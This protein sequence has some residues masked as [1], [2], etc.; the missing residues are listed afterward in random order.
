M[1]TRAKF[2]TV[3]VAVAGLGTAT[4]A[5]STPS[6]RWP[7]E[8][9]AHE[10]GTFTT[11]AGENGLAIDWLP[12]G[13]P[14][15]LPCFVEHFQS[16]STI[17]VV[18]AD[19]AGPFDYEHA[20]GALL[21]KVRMETPVLY[22][23]APQEMSLNVK[24]QFPRGLMTEWYPHADVTE[25][26][27]GPNTLRQKT[28]PAVI[29]W[30]NVLLTPRA[31]ASFPSGAGES[32]YYAARATEATPLAVGSQHERFLFYRGIADFDVP[33]SA[34]VLPN[35]RVRIGKTRGDD[36]PG[37]VLFER[38]G[39]S[40]GYRVLGTL[41]GDTTVDAPTLDGSVA[42]L[43]DHL[44]RTLTD[45]GLYQQEAAAMLETWR[46]SW[47]EDGVRVF[48]IVPP[49]LVDAILPLEIRP[50]PARV[51]RVFVGRMEVL[52]AATESAVERAIASSD[53]ATL[54]RYGRFLGPI[55]DRLMARTSSAADRERLRSVTTAAL[56][57]YL[58][59]SS[60]CE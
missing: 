36:V 18:P 27:I 17:K 25:A 19:Y 48:Y 53:A 12:L 43:R 44:Q 22:F 3:L 7:T 11:V 9:T 33:I 39:S 1:F 46:D 41:R 40:L 5:S 59:K 52:T 30:K 60:V 54:D 57:A 13:G 32:H 56:T 37:I 14:T 15:D 49:K 31:T 42:T 38:R 34:A 2:A 26:I 50:S 10:W 21:G 35:G 58:R 20:R 28:P 51:A 23:Y 47:F 55:T 24:V 4:V 6:N 8:L 16:R 45:A 29:E